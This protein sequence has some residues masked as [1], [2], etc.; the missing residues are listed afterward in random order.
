MS[1]HSLLRVQR[2]T[3][4]AFLCSALAG[5]LCS[6]PPLHAADNSTV[7]PRYRLAPGQELQYHGQSEFKYGKEDN[8]GTLGSTDDWQA[9]VVRA[10]G[11]SGWRLIIRSTTKSW[12]SYGKDAKRSDQP[13]R[14]E[15]ASFDLTPDGRVSPSNTLSSQLQPETLFPRLPAAAMAKGWEGDRDDGFV[16]LEFKADPKA[17]SEKAWV[18]DETSHSP[19]DKIYLSSARTKFTFNT[20]LGLVE[21]ADSENTQGYGFDGKGTGTTELVLV[22]DHDDAWTKRFAEEADHY[23]KAQQAYQDRLTAAN[24]DAKNAEESLAKAETVL[25]DARAELKQDVFQEQLDRQLSEHKNQIRWITDEAKEITE[26]EGKPAAEWKLDDLDGKSHALADF[27]GKVVVLDFWYRGCGWCIR[28][29]PQVQQLA[30]DFKDS[31]VAVLG[32]NKDQE[33][34]DAR[35]VVEA[36]QLS[37]PILK[38]TGVP[39]KYGVHGFPTLIVIDQQ[40]TVRDIHVGYSKTLRADV[41]KIIKDLLA[42]APPSSPVLGQVAEVPAKPAAAAPVRGDKETAEPKSTPAATSQKS[43]KVSAEEP[44]A[45]PSIMGE[46]RPDG[47]LFYSGIIIDKVTKAPIHGANVTVRRMIS[48]S[49]D[50]RILEETKH[51]TDERGKFSFVIPPKQLAVK[52]LYIELDVEHPDYSTK[53]GFGYAMDMIRKNAKLGDPP[54]YSHVELDP[55]APLTGRLVGPDGEPLAG[56]PMLAYSNVNPRDF[57]ND[58]YG[59]F[60]H[61]KSAEDGKFR[62]NMTKEGPSVFWIVPEKFAPR[63]IVSGTKRGDWGEVR[64]E[65]GVG[66]KGQVVDA[67]GTPVSGVWV[68]V[69]DEKSQGDIQMPVATALRRSGQTDA[70]GRFEIGPLKP[71]KFLLQVEGYPS[72]IRYHSRE[73]KQID[74]PAVF[75]RRTITIGEGAQEPIL[76]R[77]IP[78]VQFEA[79]YVDSKGKKRTGW[80]QFV[81]GKLDGEPYFVQLRADAE[82]RFHCLLPHG[83][84]DAKLE[85]SSNEHG[86]LRIRLGKDKPLLHG[87]EIKLGT[88]EADITDVEIVRYT[89]PIV[90]LKPVDEDGKPVVKV[91]VAGIYEVDDKDKLVHPVDGLPT[92]IF[93]EKQPGGVFRTSQLLPDEKIKFVAS[94]EGYAKVE[95]T[96][97]LPEGETR[98]LTLVLKRSSPADA[99]KPEPAETTKAAKKTDK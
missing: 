53:A 17:S 28:A 15:M 54:F 97:S 5:T 73:R 3:L 65:R 58:N 27:R 9:W 19:F 31:P 8:V 61:A 23:F 89:A 1:L 50:H 2:P 6:G 96:L 63:Q 81:F 49:Y 21:R 30:D 40:G 99:S 76:V 83:L 69:T 24:H 80:E 32:M 75:P 26:R 38:A 74:I 10:N 25:K 87:R 56:V 36:M 95:E 11:D 55:A 57:S 14:S 35:F 48:A 47:S 68:N 91:K 34:K 44:N 60:F 43:P 90:Q 84:E 41:S 98:E 70:Q 33:E 92:S 42:S 85:L 67:V 7:P 88:V 66:L 77:A 72:E 29:M 71:G 18:F 20:H 86:A 62:L 59:S 52:S 22:K 94:A 46:E 39:E 51:Q 16:H 82:G 78:H 13:A 4:C 64:M 12:S 79:Q 37:Y 93:F 45:D